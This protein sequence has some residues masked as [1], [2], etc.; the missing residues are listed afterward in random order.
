MRKKTS[1]YDDSF[2]T[3]STKKIKNEKVSKSGIGLL[4]AFW[5]IEKAVLA[6]EFKSTFFSP[7]KLLSDLGFG[8]KGVLVFKPVG[9]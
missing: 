6:Y 2:Q 7:N 8:R 3:F 1:F 9:E 4:S 5:K